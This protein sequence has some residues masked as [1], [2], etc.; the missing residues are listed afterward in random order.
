MWMGAL[1]EAER[2]SWNVADHMAIA[3]EPKIMEGSKYDVAEQRDRSMIAVAAKEK[4]KP[5]TPP[6]G[7]RG[8]GRRGDSGGGYGGGRGGGWNRNSVA[9]P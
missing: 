9:Q 5:V 3:L 1:E 7:G 2:S 4:A 8:G 6:K